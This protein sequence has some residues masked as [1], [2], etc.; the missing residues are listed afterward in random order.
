MSRFANF[1]GNWNNGAESGSRYVNTNTASN[2]NTNNG[3]R[4]VC[5]DSFLRS[6]LSNRRCRPITTKGGQL[7]CPAS[8]NTF[9]GLAERGVAF[10]E[11]RRQRFMGK[12]YKRLFEQIIAKENFQDAYLKTRKGKRNSMSYLE[13]KEYGPFNLE[14]LRQEVAD[15]AYV[16]APFRNFYIHDPKLRLISGLPFRDRIVQHAL[17]NIIEPI[18]ESTFLP[19]TFACRPNKGTHAGVKYVQSVLRK[20]KTTHFLKTDFSKYFPSIQGEK[21]YKLHESKIYCQQTL[22]LMQ[23]ITPKHETGIAIGSLASQL[24]ANLYGTL[25]DNFVHYKL[26]P[27]AWARYMDDM[28]LLD[29]DPSKLRDMKEQL[30]AFAFDEMGLRFSKWSIAPINRGINFLGYR[31]WPTHKLL[32]KQ[33]VTRAKRAIKSLKARGD[34]VALNKFLAAWVGHATWAD[35][36]HLMAHL[37]VS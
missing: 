22:R 12:K 34:T 10:C 7:G 19:Y 23:T 37:E 26:K 1:G 3:G 2:S 35:T 15:G 31:I 11:T 5:D 36:H 32:R 21:L 17:N 16:R 24:N 4:G 20:G 9:L 25:A 29:N 8:A 13:F 6:A 30:E 27:Q 28:V 33:S 14:M 18:Y